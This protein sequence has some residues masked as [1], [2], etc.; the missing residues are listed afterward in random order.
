MSVD[1]TNKLSSKGTILSYA[2]GDLS[3][4]ILFKYFWQ[5]MCSKTLET[6]Q[7]DVWHSTQS[8]PGLNSVHY[9]ISLKDGS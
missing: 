7:A 5:L 4:A 1:L 8:S 2:P 9:T 3:Q 6:K